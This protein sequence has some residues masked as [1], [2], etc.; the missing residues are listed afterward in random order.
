[1]GK[2]RPRRLGAPLSS[3]YGVRR[4]MPTT[5]VSAVEGKEYWW[6]AING[7]S[8][9]ASPSPISFAALEVRPTPEIVIGFETQEEQ[10]AAQHLNLTAPTDEV[11]RFVA[12]LN[13]RV[14]SGEVAFAKL[15]NPGPQTRGATT[16]SRAPE[17]EEN[18][19][20]AVFVAG[21]D[22][23]PDELKP[24]RA[25]LVAAR[26]ANLTTLLEQ[27]RTLMTAGHRASEIVWFITPDAATAYVTRDV[28]ASAEKGG[29]NDLAQILQTA[30]RTPPAGGQPVLCVHLSREYGSAFDWFALEAN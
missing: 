30:M 12:G 20:P 8:C 22:A 10:L 28:I 1:M 4:G 17:S 6:I 9:A 13:P 21:D 15:A 27:T 29:V 25:A 7:S 18:E 16:W 3:K 5:V 19:Q 14:Q 11:E 24:M 2:K 26:R 23:L